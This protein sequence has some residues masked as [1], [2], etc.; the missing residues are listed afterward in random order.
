MFLNVF[1]QVKSDLLF[2]ELISAKFILLY[3]KELFLK[4]C[5]LLIRHYKPVHLCK[6]FDPKIFL[7]T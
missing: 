2:H 3:Y 4:S 5:N 7:L 6:I 1:K